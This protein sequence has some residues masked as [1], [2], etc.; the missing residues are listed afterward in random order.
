M[1]RAEEEM[2]ELMDLCHKNQK[3]KKK[4]VDKQNA[5]SLNWCKIFEIIGF[6]KMFMGHSGQSAG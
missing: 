4:S 6:F 1:G 3:I 2:P 5:K